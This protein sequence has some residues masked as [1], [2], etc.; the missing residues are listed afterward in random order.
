MLDDISE[1]FQKIV[2]SQCSFEV[3]PEVVEQLLAAA[4]LSSNERVVENW[5]EDVLSRGFVEFSK[6]YSL[7]AD[8]VVRLVS[9]KGVFLEEQMGGGIQLPLKIL[10]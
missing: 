8:S 1:S 2:G 4:Y 10:F 9:C 7:K 3:D 5:V 6:R